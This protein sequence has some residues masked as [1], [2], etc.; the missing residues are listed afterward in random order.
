MYEAGHSNGSFHFDPRAATRASFEPRPAPRSKPTGPL[1]SFNQHPDS[2]LILPT[3]SANVNILN[4]K[5]KEWIKL[6]RA[7][8]LILRCFELLLAAA[9][10]T[11]MILLSNV[12]NVPKYILCIVVRRFH[13]SFKILLILTARC[14]DAALHLWNIP[15]FEK[16]IW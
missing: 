3:S 1:V 12:D 5:V 16:V 13:V 7:L 6:S 4:P 14:C 11:M 15:S 2:W 9:L 10:L 8:Q